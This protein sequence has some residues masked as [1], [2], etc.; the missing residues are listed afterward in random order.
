MFFKK[1]QFSSLKKIIIKE[2]L[3]HCWKVSRKKNKLNCFCHIYDKSKKRQNFIV[4]FRWK[5]NENSFGSFWLFEWDEKRK[6][7]FFEAWKQF[8]IFFL[9]KMKYFSTS[10]SLLPLFK[11]HFTLL[12]CWSSYSSYSFFLSV[13][14]IFF[15][16]LCLHI[17]EL[18][19]SWINNVKNSQHCTACLSLCC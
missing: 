14:T 17:S 10:S 12:H 11:W 1:K 2:P 3:K 13:I 9:T 5:E 18:F 16:F 15:S 4:I 6:R 8:F 19:L 7:K